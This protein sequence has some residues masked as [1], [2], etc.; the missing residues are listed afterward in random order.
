MSMNNEEIM[1]YEGKTIKRIVMHPQDHW[2]GDDGFTIFFTDGSVL[3]V[4]AGMG[5]G[6][7]LV[8]LE[9]SHE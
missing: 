4:G 9:H 5:Q 8:T 1:Q 3:K 2:D 6:I 7:G